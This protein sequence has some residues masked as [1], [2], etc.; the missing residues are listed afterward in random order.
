MIKM[1]QT[2]TMLQSITKQNYLNVIKNLEKNAKLLSHII[3]YD[4]CTYQELFLK[5]Y[6]QIKLI[7]IIIFAGIIF[8]YGSEYRTTITTLATIQFLSMLLTSM[9]RSFIVTSRQELTTLIAEDINESKTN[10]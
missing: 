9:Y 6:L 4:S 5:H 8:Y 10:E 1:L 2:T 3:T 7:E